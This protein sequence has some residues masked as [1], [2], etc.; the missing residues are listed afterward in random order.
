VSSDVVRM[1]TKCTVKEVKN[2][3]RQRCAVGLNSF[4][5]GLMH[6]NAGEIPLY[7]STYVEAGRLYSLAKRSYVIAA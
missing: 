5:K 2:H 6:H 4:V 1:H 3:V 7:K